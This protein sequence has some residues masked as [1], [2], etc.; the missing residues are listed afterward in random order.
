MKRIFILLGLVVALQL[1]AQNSGSMGNNGQ[2][3]SSDVQKQV[4]TPPNQEPHH[5]MGKL[6]ES[7]GDKNHPPCMQP[8]GRRTFM[9]LPLDQLSD[10]D[11]VEVEGY[12][13]DLRK[14]MGQKENELYQKKTELRCLI[15]TEKPDINQISAKLDE[16]SK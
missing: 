7:D 2:Q 1:S 15:N 16:I 12:M 13:K 8:E 9:Q 11:Q 3:P 4:S 5:L 14:I 10:K 6:I